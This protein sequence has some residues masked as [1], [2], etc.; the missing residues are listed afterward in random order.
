M[1]EA[2]MHPEAP[3]QVYQDNDAAIQIL[4]NRGSLGSRSRHISRK[5]LTSRN[6]VEDGD[7]VPVY[8]RT[9]LMLADI[10]TKALPGTQF[11]YLRDQIN[12]CSLV[13]VNRP[14]YTT[15]SCVV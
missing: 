5:V 6:K 15:P 4:L 10:G 9:N 11:E 14:S 12:G 2:G 7:T 13:K 8:K 1:P 3:T